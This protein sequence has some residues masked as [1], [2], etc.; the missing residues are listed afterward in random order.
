MSPQQARHHYRGPHLIP[1]TIGVAV[2]VGEKCCGGCW[3]LLPATTRAWIK[4]H[5]A[6]FALMKAAVCKVRRTVQ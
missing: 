5:E 3:D 1:D 4:S 6:E 2:N